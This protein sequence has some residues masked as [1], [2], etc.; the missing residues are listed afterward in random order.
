MIL[1]RVPRS[2]LLHCEA[3]I[4]G[5]FSVNRDLSTLPWLRCDR[6]AGI[7]TMRDLNGRTLGNHRVVEMIGDRGMSCA[8]A[9]GS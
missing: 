5:T 7:Q 9:E 2:A 4:S 3:V 8:L 1:P 6:L